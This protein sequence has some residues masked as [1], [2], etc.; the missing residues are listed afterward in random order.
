LPK[1]NSEVSEQRMPL[2][3]APPELRL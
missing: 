2:M 3:G 1:Y